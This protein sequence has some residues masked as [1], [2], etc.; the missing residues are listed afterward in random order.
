MSHFG[1]DLGKKVFD[2]KPSDSK[3]HGPY[4]SPYGYHVV[5]VSKNEEGRFPEMQEIKSQLVVDAKED[6][7][8][9]KTEEAIQKIIDQYNIDIVFKP[10]EKSETPKS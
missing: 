8:K 5:M 2:I 3:W 4:P 6:L 7:I 1:V 9:T 10:L